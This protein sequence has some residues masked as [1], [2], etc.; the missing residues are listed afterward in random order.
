MTVKRLMKSVA[1]A[2]AALSIAGAAFAGP[3]AQFSGFIPV[4]GGSR[5]HFVGLQQDRHYE[6]HVKSETDDARFSM[7][8]FR[9]FTLVAEAPANGKK[10]VEMEYT[11]VVSGTYRLVVIASNGAGQ[12]KGN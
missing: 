4:T 12:Y 7:R 5:Q 1:L 8:L 9:G 11:P 2:A 10:K 3:I 6:F